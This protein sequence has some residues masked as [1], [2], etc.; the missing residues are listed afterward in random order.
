LQ[1]NLSKFFCFASVNSYGSFFPIDVFPFKAEK[2]YLKDFFKLL[3]GDNRN[4]VRRFL[5]LFKSFERIKR[6]EVV[7]DAPVK[8]GVEV[9]YMSVYRCLRYASFL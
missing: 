5:F 7:L 9:S 4:F 3:L 8:N 6:N 2:S 1:V